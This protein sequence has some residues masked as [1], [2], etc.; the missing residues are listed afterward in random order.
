MCFFSLLI[1]GLLFVVYLK[2][3]CWSETLCNII[4]QNIRGVF[5]YK[6]RTKFTWIMGERKRLLGA[7]RCHFICDLY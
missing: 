4:P 5:N 7:V 2:I 1:T 3:I 6:V